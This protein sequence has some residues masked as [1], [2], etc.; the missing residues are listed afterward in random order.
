MKHKNPGVIA[1]SPD[2]QA[3]RYI[4]KHLFEMQKIKINLY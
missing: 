1:L 4:D 3:N 2:L